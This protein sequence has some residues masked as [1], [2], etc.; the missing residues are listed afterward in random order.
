MAFSRFRK[1]FKRFK[2][3]PKARQERLREDFQSRYHH[4]QLLL[5][6]NNNALDTMTRIQKALK[7]EEPF[8]MT[9]VRG[10]CTDVAARVYQIVRHLNELAPEENYKKL[11]S[12]FSDI[13][14]RIDQS[15]SAREMVTEGPLTLW[16]DT[17][18]AAN[19][20]QVGAKMATLGE[21]KN[22]LGKKAPDGFVLTAAAYSMFMQHNDLQREIDRRL[23]ASEVESG[24]ESGPE[25][26]MDKL[27][28]LSASL[29][30]CIMAAPMPEELEQ[31]IAE[32]C[33]ALRAKGYDPL[34]LAMRS[35]ALGE[36]TH[37]ASFAGQYR[38][39]LNVAVESACQVYKEIV[40][41]KYTLQAMAYR[42]HKG[43][44][45]EDVAMCVGVL[46]VVNAQ[47]G[48][49][50]YT[51]D[52][53]QLDSETVLV[54][55]VWGLPK[56]VVDGSAPV[57]ALRLS[58]QPPH[59][60]EARQTPH[61]SWRYMCR[62]GEG[63]TR[64]EL[65]ETQAAASSLTDDQAM[66]IA[67]LAMELEAHYGLPQDVEWVLTPEDEL[68]LVQTRPL[69]TAL[70]LK[71]LQSSEE[72]ALQ[73]EGG[74]APPVPEDGQQEPADKPHPS[75]ATAAPP[76]ARPANSQFHCLDKPILS[77]GVPASPG[78]ASGAVYVVLREADALTFPE[79]GVLVV[80]HSLP[81]WAA[82][83][84]RAAALIAERGSV[85]GHLANVAREFGVPAVLGLRGAV[86]AL[87][88]HAVS[89]VTVDGDK[90]N[91]YA[92]ERQDLMEARKTV[93]KPMLGTPVYETLRSA[94]EHIL[95]LALVDPEGA[96]FKPRNCRTLHDI[97]RYCHERAVIE[98]FQFGQ[99]HQFSE[100]SSRQLYTDAPMQF[101]IMDLDDG[102]RPDSPAQQADARFVR[103]EDICSIPMLALWR[104][105]S[106]KPWAGPPP[107]DAKGFMSILM[108]ATCNPHLDPAMPS[109]YTARNYFMI[110][111]NFC[112][113][114]S[115]FGF[116]FST[117]E[118]LVGDRD[119]E[120]YVTF[121]FKG[122][123]ASMDRRIGRTQLIQNLL[124]PHGFQTHVMEDALA[125]RAEGMPQHRM[126]KLLMI[127]GFLTIHTR[128][129]DMVM[130]RS[131]SVRGFLETMA[132]EIDAMLQTAP[133][134]PASDCVGAAHGSQ[135]AASQEEE[136]TTDGDPSRQDSEM[137]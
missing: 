7:G 8:S 82:L 10:A 118:A 21:A 59:T 103:L 99:R 11:F 133:H 19:A 85:T 97:T 136:T 16:L 130:A 40:A 25:S 65:S 80:A 73:N 108:E 69:A 43:I 28:A 95:P 4:F 98:M 20:N 86:A 58:R 120:N 47:A 27:F 74:S 116:H 96:D 6:S 44:R 132:A 117:V 55:S 17:I 127:V 18:S 122:G 46:P 124:N 134:P 114:Q 35:S 67:A 135:N 125:A 52:P 13:Q 37:G 83:L 110:A 112:S 61:K 92:G 129:L 42:L 33:A 109:H 87:Q 49:V 131:E 128:Q 57:D 14:E 68:V 34:R 102:I 22:D 75:E 70:H 119:R 105:I 88:Q 89:A 126:E 26:G 50:A 38:S 137:S 64:Q 115:R 63:L 12:R 76:P 48:G 78:L 36:D 121:R 94:A 31:A 77:G 39:Q 79:N 123:A 62:E 30:Q 51:R 24:A 106:A 66:R 23:Q 93:H 111:R 1:F 9:F 100:R 53:L 107:V 56:G 71:R 101:W 81:R 104:G 72:E 2:E 3:E 5:T 113:L 90:G 54:N 84:P 15:L 60:L 41:G 45:D 32:G 91:I 29:Q